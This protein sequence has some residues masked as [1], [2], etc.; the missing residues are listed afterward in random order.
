[1]FLLG[2]SE[3]IRNLRRNILVIIQMVAVYIIALFTV[4]AF[5]EQYS[6]M[7][8]ISKVFDDTGM[9]FFKE[10][11]LGNDWVEKDKLYDKLVKVEEIG[12]SIC[13]N[14][15]DEQNEDSMLKSADVIAYDPNVITYTPKLIAGQWCEEVKQE[16]GV[17]NTVVSDNLPFDIQ[18]GQVI[19]LCGY[20]F[21]I[22]G[23]VSSKELLYGINYKYGYDSASYLDFYASW[24]DR[25]NYVG[26]YLFIIPYNSML[27]EILEKENVSPELA[28]IWG[29]YGIIDFQ[30]DITEEEYEYNVDV[31]EEMYN[32]SIGDDIFNTK[33]V[34][35]YSWVLINIKIMPMLILLCIIVIALIIS[36]IIS[37]AIN[38]L[39]EKKNYGIY[40]ICGNDWGNTFKFSLAS[41][42]ILAATSLVIAGCGYVII[43]ALSIFSGLSLSFTWMHVVMLAAITLIL[44]IITMIVPFCMLRKIQPVSILKENDK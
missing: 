2:L 31:L 30:D 27:E 26:K 29:S 34:Y 28:A 17:I 18:L 41:W 33:Q 3:F 5:V 4:S 25:T 44:L 11:L 22:V 21:K 15:L 32:R 20:K 12:H 39:Y 35:D 7:D 16:K 40:F 23:V 9:I 43:G 13:W 24:S 6:L 10:N 8:G 42:A 37:V 36:L 1:M 14:M 38:V 19:E